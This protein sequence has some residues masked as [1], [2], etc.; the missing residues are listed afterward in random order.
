MDPGLHRDDKGIMFKIIIKSILNRKLS[1]FLTVFSIAISIALFVGVERVRLGAQD[2]FTNTISKTDLVVGARGSSIQLLLY[3]VFHIGNAT[4]NIS[5]SFR[6]STTTP[7][8]KLCTG[9]E[10]EIGPSEELTP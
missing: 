8:L 5:W 2:S 6:V 4:N 3:T 10:K 7:R 1:F 9:L